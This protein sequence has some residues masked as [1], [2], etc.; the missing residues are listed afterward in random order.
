[1]GVGPLQPDTTYAFYFYEWD[2]VNAIGGPAATTMNVTTWPS[3]L[4]VPANVVV[5][6][7]SSNAVARCSISAGET[8]GFQIYQ[9]GT[10]IPALAGGTGP[11][12]PYIDPFYFGIGFWGTPL[13]PNTTYQLIAW[14]Q[15]D[16]V[17]TS[18]TTN[19]F[20]T[21]PL[22]GFG[23]LSI[24]LLSSG[25][26]FLSFVGNAGT[27]Y[28]LERSFSLAPANWVALVTNPAGTDGLLVITNMPNASTNNFWRI[29]SVP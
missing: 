7:T 12:T 5:T 29:R 8:V 9:N 23:H 27:N 15:L 6:P 14:G 26:V 13:Q 10:N 18:C 3:L 11:N 1:M 16:G 21:L 4:V 17:N 25:S 20:T 24:Q 28:A 19:T 2:W 22:T